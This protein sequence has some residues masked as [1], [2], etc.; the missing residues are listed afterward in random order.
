MNCYLPDI[1]YVRLN[2]LQSILSD[3]KLVF[4]TSQ[5]KPHNINK[6]YPEY[7]K[8]IDQLSAKQRKTVL[9]NSKIASQVISSYSKTA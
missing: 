7:A 9:E 8:E 6:N 4:E 2:F 5:I 3:E 1:N